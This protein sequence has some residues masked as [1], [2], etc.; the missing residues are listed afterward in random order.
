MAEILI[1]DDDD[2]LRLA[3]HRMLTKRGHR[4]THVDD[5]VKALEVLERQRFDLAIVD[6][7]MPRKD[8][9]ELTI[10]IKKLYPGLPIIA[11]SGGGRVSNME[12][13]DIAQS[14]GAGSTLQKPFSFVKLRETINDLLVS[15]DLSKYDKVLTLESW[16]DI[17]ASTRGF[18][19]P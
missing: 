14:F 17:E 11:I 8:G 13:L 12:L 19:K 2:T 6:I 9:I 15:N 10:E 4:V 5:G 16:G 7:I 3:L 1:A 18:E